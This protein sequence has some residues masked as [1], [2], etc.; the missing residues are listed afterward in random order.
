MRYR[1]YPTLKVVI[2]IKEMKQQTELLHT[3]MSVK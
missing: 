1:V 3:L 2:K